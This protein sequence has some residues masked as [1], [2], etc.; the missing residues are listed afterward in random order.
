MPSHCHHILDTSSQPH[1]GTSQH[2]RQLD[3]FG[4]NYVRLDEKTTADWIVFAKA[5]AKFLHY[6]DSKN[7]ANGDWQPF[8]SKNPSTTLATLAVADITEFAA[9]IQKLLSSLRQQDLQV[10]EDLLRQ[11]F[12]LLFDILTTLAFRLDEHIQHLPDTLPAKESLRNRL[13]KVLAPALTKWIAWHKAA[14]ESS[15]PNF[16]LLS[17]DTD[18]LAADWAAYQV[19]GA[20]P[21]ST[22]DFYT[23]DALAFSA[24][25]IL[26][27]STDWATYAANIAP[28]FSLFG[29][30]NMG[31][32]TATY[33]Q[34][35]LGHFFFNNTIERFLAAFSTAKQQ[36]QLALE[37]LLSNYNQHEPHFA[38]FL[39]FLRMLQQE[40]LAI[41]GLVDRHLRF[42]YEGV[43]RLFP[44]SAAPARA[45][46]CVCTAAHTAA[47]AHLLLEASK[48]TD[49]ALIKEG[50]RFRAGKDALGKPI[51]FAST[52]DF[53]LHRAK[54]SELR[55]IFKVPEDPNIYRFGDAERAV[56]RPSDANRYFAA[57]VA[58][59]ADGLGAPLTSEDESWHPVA[60]RQLMENGQYQ[61]DMP[62]ARI[63]FAIASNYFYLQSGQRFL[64]LQLHGTAIEALNQCNFTLSLTTEKGWYEKNAKCVLWGTEAYL[65]TEIPA[66]APPILPYDAAMHGGNFNT[67]FPLLKA[68]LR[69]EENGKYPYE[70]LKNTRLNK[71]ALWVLATGRRD[72]MLSGNN[73]K[74]DPTKPFAPFTAS[75]GKGAALLLG[76]KEVF[77]KKA[78]VFLSV[79][80][81]QGN[82][83]G[84][85]FK[86]NGNVVNP[87]VSLSWL[88]QGQWSNQGA[89]GFLPRANAMAYPNFT[90]EENSVIPP[91]FTANAPYSGTEAAGFIRFRLDSD[92]GHN[93]YP[94]ALAQYAKDGGNPPAIPYEAEILDIS[95]S[96][97]A[98]QELSLVA[99]SNDANEATFFHLHPFGEA[100]QKPQSAGLP[101]LPSLIDQ[102]DITDGENT[103]IQE[104][105]DGGALLI[106]IED[107]QVP[108]QLALLF[109]VVPGTTDPLLA[110]PKQQIRWSYLAANEW[111][112]L[113]PQQ[114]SDQTRQLLSSGIINF[115]LPPDADTTNSLLP[116]GKIWIKANVGSAV[117]TLSRLLCVKAQALLV[118]AIEQD[119]DP[120]LWANPLPPETI[121]KLDVARADIKKISQAFPSFGGRA[122]ENK[123]SY[124]QRV[125]E[126]LRHKDRAINRWDYEHLLLQEFPQLHRVK[127]L[128]HLRYEPQADRPIYQ[129]LAA[130]YTTIVAVKK[131]NDPLL[132]DPLRPYVSVEELLAMEEFLKKRS[133][134]FAQLQLRNPAFEAVQVV[135]NACL[136]PGYDSS[137]YQQQLNEDI[138]RFFTPWAFDSSKTVEFGGRIYKSSLVDFIEELPYINFVTKV[139]LS[140]NAD[141]QQQNVEEVY[142][143]KK[144]AVLVAA[145]EHRITIIEQKTTPAQQQNCS[146]SSPAS[147]QPISLTEKP[148]VS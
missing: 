141:P 34:L 129:E 72:F 7:E 130:G 99:P 28:D 126:R 16:P 56:Y 57:S 38:L 70:S 89:A 120:Q 53:V 15:L 24:D 139:Q 73:G 86:P 121:N 148:P 102:P 133:T 36:S 33:I 14:A 61:I 143:S 96:Y 76:D 6:Y 87:A 26:D 62:T 55:S 136:Y 11:H 116:K 65:Y 66:D 112:A 110:K 101:L 4:P 132:Q 37:S 48:T 109:Q 8:W 30:L 46:K 134:C 27:S 80:W 107:M 138:I 123:E 111:K 125:S 64:L 60:Q 97:L 50:T 2:E 43:L 59:S 77:Q 13:S 45:S 140:N 106:G 98:S 145:K 69:H 42:Y 115:S 51:H 71:I 124:Q 92:F 18:Q 93:Q 75:P 108:G 20:A 9:D 67:P 103:I 104:G 131:V 58:N 137:F 85:F 147:Q 25:W 41:N 82:N 22:A 19:F 47:A 79:N 83:Y 23:A 127:C 35:G 32:S 29:D 54:V 118:E 128:P 95:L 1:G 142:A 114:V 74:L 10:N 78:S 144:V 135:L 91:D 21:L 39:A 49:F 113:E 40:Q 3:A 68:T 31:A 88:T 105:K 94:T 5:Y 17:A 12:R 122:A 100:A 81:K 63:G 146:C 119:N 84:N 90:L 44:K 117:D 52:H